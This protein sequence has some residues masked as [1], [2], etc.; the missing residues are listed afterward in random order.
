MRAVALYGTLGS[1]VLTAVAATPAG[2]AA[3]SSA[4]GDA[5][6]VRG[7]AVAVHRAAA[8]GI[9]FGRCPKTENLPDPVQ[10]GTVSVPLDYAHPGGRKIS[11]TVSRVRAT[12]AG[13][14]RQGA[15]LFNPGGPGASGMDF[16]MFAPI[17]EW[18]S[19]SKAYDFVG[20]AP[21]GVGRSARVSCQDAAEFAK[22]PTNLPLHPSEEY[23]NLRKEKA[24]VYARGCSLRMGTA[25]R[26]YTSLN[27]ARDLDVI[28]AALGERKLNF[29]GSSYGTYIGSVYATLFP[30][31]V[32]RM[33]F[34]SAVNPDPRQIWYQANL[35]QSL[36]FETRWA[37]WRRWVA[38]HDAVF[39]LGRTQ[40]AVLANYE[41]ARARLER[42]PA[43]GT[44][45]SEQLQEAFLK[46]GYYDAYW[47]RRAQALSAY[48]RGDPKRLI[49]QAEPRAEDAA[50]DENGLAV[51]TAVECNDAP[52]PTSWDTWDRDNTRLAQTAP[53][54][55]WDNAWMNLPCAYWTEPRQ[56][57]LDVRTA[58]GALP[59][60]LILAAE[61][62]A[63]TPYPG[64]LELQRRLAGSSL[65]TERRSGT[66][67]IA[68]GDNACVNRHLE[69]YL[70]RGTTPG[71]TRRSRR[72]PST[73]LCVRCPGRAS[74]AF[75]GEVR[76]PLRPVRPSGGRCWPTTRR[77]APGSSAN[78]R[79]APSARS[80]S[81]RRS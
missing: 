36:A 10:C 54:E 14:A 55:T 51:Y 9:A 44:V 66:H 4:A 3:P 45:G 6:E 73:A 5:P 32:R 31:H 7:T 28:R 50:E 72:Y 26:H 43:G 27:N 80:S 42:E 38:K 34:D 12:G 24:G 63:A 49:E 37:D 46:V 74:D 29:L 15:L 1:L 39:H 20:Y 81:R 47:P 79:A 8:A 78:L 2:S 70:L 77:H 53:F 71:P 18:R 19:L 22:A 33:V 30:G 75:P 11:L 76:A 17:E 58:A 67:G 59:P 64:A 65:V 16:P 21:R 60:V 61:R 35:D 56:Q 52:W 62:D 48:L 57:P 69:A 40:Q 41:K 68:G 23:K 25:L 13:S